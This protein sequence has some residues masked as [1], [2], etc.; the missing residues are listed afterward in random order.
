MNLQEG[1]WLEAFPR[2][3]VTLSLY[4]VVG[5]YCSVAMLC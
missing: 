2:H 5:E 4:I 1:A 3:L